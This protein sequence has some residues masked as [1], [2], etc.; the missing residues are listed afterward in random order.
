MSSSVAKIGGTAR[1]GAQ[2]APY[3]VVER[4]SESD[5]IASFLLAPCDG[6]RVPP[7]KAGQYLTLRLADNLLRT[8]TISSSPDQRDSY[9]ITVKREPAPPGRP[10]LP[11]G[12][13][14]GHLHDFV[15]PGSVLEVLE[16]RGAFLLDET[17]QRAVVLLSGG[18]GLTPMVSM[19]HRLA[20][21][22]RPVHFI[23]A[24]ENGSVH[25]LRDEVLALA[26]LRPV[27]RTRFVYRTP[28]AGDVALRLF[29]SAG[30]VD[31]QLLQSLL[32]LEDYD[33]YLCGPPGFMQAVYGALLGL[34]VAKARIKYEFFGP[35]TVL[36]PKA[37]EVLAAPS[38]SLQSSSETE[39]VFTRSGKSAPWRNFK[40]TLLEFAEQQG[41]TP[42]FSC[43]AGIC[44]S[45]E[46]ELLEGAVRYD[47][48]PLD[49]PA[50]GKALICL[51][52]PASPRV[53]LDL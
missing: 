26:R 40:G 22:D 17:S 35:A 33:F 7:F 30:V 42:E 50:E 28:S 9:R 3:R 32:P 16:P 2:F 44:N 4:K 48:T 25:A 24:C 31:R 13:G 36:E 51:A 20:G 38:P 29:D 37:P 46:C 21:Q 1:S 11:S 47:E 39:I 41:L 19:L 6:D 53:R 49:A 43:R 8:Y 10:E 27:I 12:R 18:V 5:V 34:G 52:R 23:H 45:C 14:S 15:T